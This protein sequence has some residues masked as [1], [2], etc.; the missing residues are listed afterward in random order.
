MYALDFKQLACN[1]NWD[2]ETLMSEFNWS[3]HD[4]VNNLLLSMSDP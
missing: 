4:D 2:E 1:I 3:L